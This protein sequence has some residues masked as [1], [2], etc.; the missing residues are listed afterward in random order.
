MKNII[1]ITAAVALVAAS[2][3][4]R[5][6]SKAAPKTS[7]DSFSYI[8]G[9]QV[10]NY[11]RMQGV[12]KLNYGALIK[13]IEEAMTKDSGFAIHPD[14]MEMIQSAYVMKEQEKK[15]KQ[16]QEETKKWMAENAKKPGVSYLPSKGQFKLVKAGSGPAPGQWDTV[17]YHL[18]AKD[19]KGAIKGDTRA[20]GMAPREVLSKIYIAPV[21]EAFQKVTEGA[22]F[23]VVIQNDVYLR[24]GRQEKLEDRYGVTIF[25]VELLKVIPG[26][27]PEKQEQEQIPGIK[28]P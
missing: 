8:V 4:R 22:V 11:M 19:T 28:M 12:D 9:N 25:T 1:T 15:I 3:G 5:V 13:G 7:L 14:K 26:R 17:V 2:C 20:N 16:Y 6:D 27:E 10:G 21:Q 18:V 24:S 23:E